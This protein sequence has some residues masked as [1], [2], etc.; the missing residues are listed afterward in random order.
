[1]PAFRIT[2]DPIQP[3]SWLSM[4][5]TGLHAVWLILA[6][7]FSGDDCPHPEPPQPT[8]DVVVPDVIPAP[9]PEPIPAPPA[10]TPKPEGKV[11]SIAIDNAEGL[12]IDPESDEGKHLV[13]VSDL[14]PSAYTITTRRAKAKPSTATV[15][16][17]G[18][19]IPAPVPAPV[20]PKPDPKPTPP[21]PAPSL[22]GFALEV[23]NAA[24]N[25]PAADCVKLADNYESVASQIAA[26]GIKS[27]PDAQKKLEAMNAALALDKPA[28]TP[29][30]AWLGGQFAAKA[31]TLPATAE[32]MAETAKGL[33]AAGGG[34]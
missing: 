23:Y 13:G 21:T 6:L 22:T 18:G 20:P 16:I 1:M 33:R 3:P 11:L 25:L 8:P 31:N 28:W 4:V 24:K 19:V 5:N 30:A 17:G 10:P 12:S 34:K 9:K 27:L 7:I 29:F 2:H 26:G 15:M 14:P 32:L